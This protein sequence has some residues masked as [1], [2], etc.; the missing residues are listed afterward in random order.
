MR[1]HHLILMADAGCARTE[2]AVVE[3]EL[4]ARIDRGVWR[5][6]G[7]AKQLVDVAA[8]LVGHVAARLAGAIREDENILP[9]SLSL[10]RMRAVTG[11]WCRTRKPNRVD[12]S[13]LCGRKLAA[14]GKAAGPAIHKRQGRLGPWYAC[15]PASVAARPGINLQAR[16]RCAVR[17]PWRSARY[18]S[19]ATAGPIC[20]PAC[21][22]RWQRRACR[23]DAISVRSS[24]DICGTADAGCAPARSMS[25][26][27]ASKK[28][29]ARLVTCTASP[30]TSRSPREVRLSKILTA[31]S[32]AR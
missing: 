19:R 30:R 8:R 14:C 3:G 7:G 13:V 24:R 27:R 21:A 16:R 1:R 20:A 23:P 32:P 25:T 5:N 29:R 11:M 4:L 31:R 15:H 9:H 6:A 28:E 2:A 10:W 12:G 26:P 18:A 17:R 22:R